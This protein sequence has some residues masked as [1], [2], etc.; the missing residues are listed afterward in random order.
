MRHSFS[1][2]VRKL[3]LYCIVPCRYPGSQRQAALQ[4][5]RSSVS[6]NGG[7]LVIANVKKLFDALGDCIVD[8]EPATRIDTLG[9]LSDLATEADVE[10]GC[11]P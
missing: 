1:N 10:F 3:K 5:L 8:S 11:V 2:S 6:A 4:W 7:T 9:F